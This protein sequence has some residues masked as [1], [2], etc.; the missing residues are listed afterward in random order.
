EARIPDCLP[1]EA[2]PGRH[3]RMGRRLRLR[4][5]GGGRLAR[6]R[7]PSVH[8]N[9]PRRRRVLVRR[10]RTRAGAVRRAPPDPV[11][12]GVLRQQPAPR[13]GRAG[14]CQRP[15]PGLHRRRS[16]ARLP[17][18]GD[19]RR[20]R[21]RQERRRQPARGREGVRPAGQPGRRTGHQARDRELR[22]GG[23]APRR[24]P[25]QPGLLARAVGVDVRPRALPQL[26]PVAPRVDGHRPGRGA[27]PLRRQ[28]RARA[29]EGRADLPRAPQP[30]RL[31]GPRR[32]PAGPLGRRVV[33]LPG[34]GPRR[35]RLAPRRGHP[36]RGRLRRCRVRRARGSRLGRNGGPHRDGPARCARHPATPVGRV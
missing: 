13:S 32:P 26:R 36:L 24:V 28:G 7:R 33:A 15:R 23:L 2:Q 22:D 5:A 25:R 8:R 30:L 16:A 20:T 27:P 1:A 31:A 34:A 14:R 12:A 11:V 4:G 3:R 19:L 21:P 29:G 10:R 18:R 9:A 17:D 6:P 35:G